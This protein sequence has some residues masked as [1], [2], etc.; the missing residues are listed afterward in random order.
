MGGLNVELI[1]MKN[2][3]AILKITGGEMLSKNNR[4]A[5]LETVGNHKISV[6]NFK[7]KE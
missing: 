7:G 3:C 6:S 1:E 2:D 5:V 4:N